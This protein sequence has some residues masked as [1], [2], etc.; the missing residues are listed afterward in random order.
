MK[1]VARRAV[2]A[3][4]AGVLTTVVVVGAQQPDNTARNKQDRNPSAKTADQQSNTKADIDVTRRIRQSIVDDKSL[5]T[6][7]HNVKIITRAG[8]VTLKGP[9]QTD[10]EKRAVEAKAAEVAGAG[11]VTSEVSVTKSTSSKTS[12]SQKS[13]KGAAAPKER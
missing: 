9:V 12:T 6:N 4:M 11:N 13:P 3:M 7:A 1:E 5:S 8:K 10:A 2:V